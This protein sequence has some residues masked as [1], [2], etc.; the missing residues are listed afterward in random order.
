MASASALQQIR[1]S[2]K[3]IKTSAFPAICLVA[4]AGFWLGVIRIS[5][6][7]SSY[8]E[9]TYND[10]L[11]LKNIGF[12]VKVYYAVVLTF[13][14]EYIARYEHKY[15]WHSRYLWFLHATHHHQRAPFGAGP[16]KKDS[17]SNRF[18]APKAEIFE[19]NDI[20]ALA[21]SSLAIAAMGWVSCAED[22]KLLH[23]IVF[24]SSVGISI[25]GTSYFI[26]HDLVSHERGGKA[27]A[28]FLK[29]IFPIISRCAEVHSKYHH[30]I[31]DV[32]SKDSD[33]YGVPYGFWL[34]PQEVE[35]W[36]KYRKDL[37]IPLHFRFALGFGV[38]FFLY[39]L[40]IN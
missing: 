18:V 30:S 35:A 1:T 28:E 6:F 11:S 38:A 8:K 24:G 10:D 20:F 23:E 2:S 15:L 21:F 25:Y 17:E 3:V 32:H 9:E 5:L 36:G 29:N 27:L 19:A 4:L 33:P 26:G 31:V 16:T 39:S 7:S 37:G 12:V 22:R 34:G 14:M 13:S 40:V